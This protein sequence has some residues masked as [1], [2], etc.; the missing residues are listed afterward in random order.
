MPE[1]QNFPAGKAKTQAYAPKLKNSSTFLKITQAS[2]LLEEHNF[3]INFI[4]W[5]LHGSQV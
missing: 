1:E 4:I 3:F 5:F 2:L